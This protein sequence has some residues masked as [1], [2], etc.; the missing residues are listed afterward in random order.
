MKL[1]CHHIYETK[2]VISQDSLLTQV[3]LSIRMTDHV[4]KRSA[5]M[6]GNNLAESI[7]CCGYGFYFKTMIIKYAKKIKNCEATRK[8][9]PEANIWRWIRQKLKLMNSA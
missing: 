9:S 7:V 6:R 2:A 8:A 1:K 5:R 4:K 3:L